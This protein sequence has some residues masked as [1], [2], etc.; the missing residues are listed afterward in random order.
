[1]NAKS[2]QFIRRSFAIMKKLFPA[3]KKHQA[4]DDPAPGCLNDSGERSGR[5]FVAC[6]QGIIN[7][8]KN[9]N[10]TETAAT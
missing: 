9:E 8:N 5:G 10:G 6:A 2:H 7:Y 3:N 4:D 1:M